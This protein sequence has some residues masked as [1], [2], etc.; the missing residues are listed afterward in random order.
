M[1]EILYSS[2]EINKDLIQKFTENT[3]KAFTPFK[4]GIYKDHVRYESDMNRKQKAY[5]LLSIHV[6]CVA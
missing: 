5:R 6:Y 1:F 3:N 2:Y 4:Y